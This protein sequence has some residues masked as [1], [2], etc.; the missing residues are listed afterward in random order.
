MHEVAHAGSLQRLKP[1]AC[2]RGPRAGTGL[3]L[4][5][6]DRH[7]SAAGSVHEESLADEQRRDREPETDLERPRRP[8]L[9]DVIAERTPSSGPIATGKISA[10]RPSGV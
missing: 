4:E 3:E 1:D 8:G 7:V 6:V 10:S 5:R 2:V 9:D